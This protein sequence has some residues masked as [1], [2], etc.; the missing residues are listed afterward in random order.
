[1]FD[2][3]LGENVIYYLLA[4]LSGLIVVFNI[5]INSRLAKKTDVFIGT[6][7]NFFIA[8]TASLIIV[9][10]LKEKVQEPVKNA[11]D[12][13]FI[14]YLAGFF[15]VFV[16]LIFNVIVHKIPVIYST[17]LAFIGQLG[18]GVVLD[19]FLGNTISIGKVAG[20]I[21]ISIGFLYNMN[22]DRKISFSIK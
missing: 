12:V 21:L 16:V 4:F 3:F 2:N 22:V 17:I 7:A 5:V 10:I 1:M 13:P 8:M 14:Y 20:L 9:V 18:M 19:I 15:G 6:I 11:G